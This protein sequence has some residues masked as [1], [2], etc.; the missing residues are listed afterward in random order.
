MLIAGN[1]PLRGVARVVRTRAGVG[2]DELDL[3]ANQG[4]DAARGVDLLG[5]HF[6]ALDGAAAVG[7][8]GP[9]EAI[10]DRDLDF[11][12]LRVQACCNRESGDAGECER[13]W[14]LESSFHG[15]SFVDG[16]AFIE[17]F[18]PPSTRTAARR[19]LGNGCDTHVG[20]A[21]PF[22]AQQ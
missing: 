22:I 2:D 12:G 8:I 3:R 9:R 7:G 4:L 21:N 16:T 10:N 14:S 13:K 11:L 20:G 19:I 6:R 5:R 15:V 17:L 1:D 18:S